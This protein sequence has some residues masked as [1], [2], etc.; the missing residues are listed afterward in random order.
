MSSTSPGMSIHPSVD[1]SCAMSPIG[2]SGVRSSGP[3]GSFVPGC[4]GGCIG[5]GRS[6]SALYHAV[7]I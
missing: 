3:I 5:S 4:N 6:G 2:K 1:T 7:G